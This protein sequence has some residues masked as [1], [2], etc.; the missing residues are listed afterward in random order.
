M[1][2]LCLV[3]FSPS[4]E[5]FDVNGRLRCT[6]PSKESRAAFSHEEGERG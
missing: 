2:L 1:D 3:I 4:A 6:T 5:M